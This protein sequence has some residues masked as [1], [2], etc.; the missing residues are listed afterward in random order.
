MN[1]E[2]PRFLV[3]TVSHRSCP[4]CGHREAG[5]VLEDGSFLRLSPGMTVGI[6][7]PP[8]GLPLEGPET[9]RIA[10]EEKESVIYKLYV[11]E[12]LR[13]DKDLR[14][15]YGVTVK[16]SLFKGEMSGDLYEAAYLEKLQRLI[17][18]QRD[19]HPA[20]VLDRYFTS[21]HLASGDA[22]QVVHAMWRELDEIRAPVLAVRAWL[23]RGDEGSLEGMI[24]PKTRETME[25]EPADDETVMKELEAL[26]LEEFLGLL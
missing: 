21:P 12:P 16:E 19:V 3:A 25:N 13:G 15:K 9:E 26:C 6:P 17:E 14:A 5:L 4:L 23:Q 20:V 18:N 10:D 11:P 24:R 8:A 2:K 7:A 1:I 22:L